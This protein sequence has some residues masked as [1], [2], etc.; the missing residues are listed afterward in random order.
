MGTAQGTV[1]LCK[2]AVWFL[3]EKVPVPNSH[4]ICLEKYFMP[5]TN[6]L[7][8]LCHHPQLP[9]PGNP[10]LCVDTFHSCGTAAPYPKVLPNQSLCT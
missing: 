3:L 10:L 8:T 6:F 1:T 5:R 9:V 7:D 4:E 2:S